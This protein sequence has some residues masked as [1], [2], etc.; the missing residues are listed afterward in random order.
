MPV[1]ITTSKLSNASRY[2]G[3]GGEGRVRGDN[4][5][6]KDLERNVK[7]VR[8]EVKLFKLRERFKI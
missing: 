3:I 6:V 2:G 5:P 4:H 1:E 7:N 8:L